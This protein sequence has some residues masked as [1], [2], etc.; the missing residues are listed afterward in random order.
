MKY[1]KSLFDVMKLTD[2]ITKSSKNQKTKQ[3]ILIDENKDLNIKVTKAIS[4]KHPTEKILELREEEDKLRLKS[5]E[6]RQAL[7]NLEGTS[8]KSKSNK[9][10]KFNTE[11]SS[12]LGT[13]SSSLLSADINDDLTSK[14][15]KKDQKARENLVIDRRRL[16][17]F[18]K[19][20]VAP[21]VPAQYQLHQFRQKRIAKMT[22][23]QK[24]MIKAREFVVKAG[25]EV[26]LHTQHEWQF[27]QAVSF[28][29]TNACMRV[30]S[31]FKYLIYQQRLIRKGRV[32]RAII[33]AKKCIRN[34][35]KFKHFR[36]RPSHAS[37]ITTYRKMCK[38]FVILKKLLIKRKAFIR[39]AQSCNRNVARKTLKIM[40]SFSGGR[41]KRQAR[42]K[43]G[44]IQFLRHEAKY[45]FWYWYRVTK[46]NLP[47]RRRAGRIK[48]WQHLRYL[49]REKVKYWVRMTINHRR[50]R[51]VNKY[52]ITN[53]AAGIKCIHNIQK[54]LRKIKAYRTLEQVGFD[55]YRINLCG[56]WLLKYREH[57]LNKNSIKRRRTARA[58]AAMKQVSNLLV[59]RG[60]HAL[61][62]YAVQQTGARRVYYDEVRELKAYYY[63]QVLGKLR[64][65]AAQNRGVRT[66]RRRVYSLHDKMLCFKGFS[67]FRKVLGRI[68]RTD[69]R[70]HQL[71][72]KLVLVNSEDSIPAGPGPISRGIRGKAIGNR[73][74]NSSDNNKNTEKS[75]LPKSDTIDD[76]PPS[77]SDVDHSS[78]AISRRT[79][80]KA[81]PNI[82]PNL[83]RVTQEK[84]LAR[85]RLN[86]LYS[87]GICAMKALVEYRSDMN[88]RMIKVDKIRKYIACRTVVRR[89]RNF[90]SIV[91]IPGRYLNGKGDRLRRRIAQWKLLHLLHDASIYKRSIRQSQSYN[92]GRKL[93]EIYTIFKG[94]RRF[95]TRI[96][97]ELL[98]LS[99]KL[100]EALYKK[101][102]NLLQ[103]GMRGYREWYEQLKHV[104]LCEKRGFSFYNK[105]RLS[106][107]FH[108][109]HNFVRLRRHNLHKYHKSDKHYHR[110]LTI[111]CM[112]LLRNMMK[113]H[114]RARDYLKIAIRRRQHLAM[115]V[116]R[117]FCKSHAHWY[118]GTQAE[119]KRIHKATK[120]HKNLLKIGGWDEFKINLQKTREHRLDVEYVTNTW[121]KKII[122]K[123]F[124]FLKCEYHEL[125]KYKVEDIYHIIKR[126][127]LRIMVKHLLSMRSMR[128][129]HQ[130][131]LVRS[132]ERLVLKGL[133]WFHYIRQTFVYERSVFQTGKTK[134][135]YTASSRFFHSLK[136]TVESGKRNRW[137]LMKRK[138]DRHWWR[139]HSSVAISR[140]K[141]AVIRRKSYRRR[142]AAIR[143]LRAHKGLRFMQ[144]FTRNTR[145]SLPDMKRMKMALLVSTATAEHKEAQVIYKRNARYALH[146][147]YAIYK[148]RRFKI[149]LKWLHHISQYRKPQRILVPRLRLNRLS[150]TFNHMVNLTIQRQSVRPF[151]LHCLAAW[152]KQKIY[153]YFRHW[154][155]VKDDEEYL[156]HNLVKHQKKKVFVRF[157]ALISRRRRRKKNFKLANQSFGASKK[158]EVFHYLRQTVLGRRVVKRVRI[159]H[160]HY[161]LLKWVDFVKHNKRKIKLVHKVK[162]FRESSL[163]RYLWLDYFRRRRM[164]LKEKRSRKRWEAYYRKTMLMRGLQGLEI[165]VGRRWALRQRNNHFVKTHFNQFK[166]KL[167]LKTMRKWC[168]QEKEIKK[169]RKIRIQKI[170]IPFIT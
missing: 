7:T 148:R 111:P 163:L 44:Y 97:Q 124:A 36:L 112:D 62:N 120:Y 46:K 153:N 138:P 140:W 158:Y 42:I 118:K 125:L 16:S 34:F 144:I 71:A 35:R 72:Q 160:C 115:M 15:N 61:F 24:Q 17:L 110:H 88:I 3:D 56:N 146:A 38:V 123:V 143:R 19:E 136:L 48:K 101:W 149:A 69:R 70:A 155:Q 161:A 73:C 94:L 52:I 51:Y 1:K 164:R 169:Q 68:T 20:N 116:I 95:R 78:T 64:I 98:P 128:F 50:L 66:S 10:V 139:H 27:K 167:G 80:A 13:S 12:S 81:L 156:M 6:V 41:T 25:E 74:T 30:V 85:C 170:D 129:R 92:R 96:Q 113:R 33:L 26:M 77:H 76:H 40:K 168:Q 104:Y 58:R 102:R 126:N 90:R 100:D 105:R 134:F 18:A 130:V 8:L 162:D 54:Y 135:Y 31:H 37:T 75:N 4:L 79:L 127:S 93:N 63:Y 87:K 114:D 142:L 141:S 159:H 9:S 145:I 108:N 43:W 121:H 147:G 29:H 107:R 152:S 49:C 119:R 39:I 23:Y 165:Q 137:L 47:R 21:I 65:K 86:L 32:F 151:L 28:A 11:V 45:L 99:R 67:L 157:R 83:T 5:K 82:L 106:V 109:W 59:S 53:H 84:N 60:L 133:R 14:M 22:A 154:L 117:E 131:S 2:G 103:I 132:D 122:S 89:L 91:K 166:L 55:H 150:R 57:L